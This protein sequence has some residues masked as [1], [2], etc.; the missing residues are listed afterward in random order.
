MSAFVTGNAL[1]YDIF[2]SKQLLLHSKS[3]QVN[4]I[5][6]VEIWIDR[7]DCTRIRTGSALPAS[8][9][10]GATG[11]RCDF[12]FKMFVVIVDNSRFNEGAPRAGNINSINLE[13]VVFS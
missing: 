4:P 10:E 5:S 3:N 1:P 11:E 12:L 8:V 2:V 6:R 13:L 9:N 7:I